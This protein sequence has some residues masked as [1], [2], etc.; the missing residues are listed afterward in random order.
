MQP[1]LR[2]RALSVTQL[3]LEVKRRLEPGFQDRIV[4]GEVSNLKIHS[5]GNRY[6]SLKDSKSQV[7][8]I[9]GAKQAKGLDFSLEEG[10]RVVV[11][12]SLQL[13]PDRGSLQL[14]VRTAK[15]DGLGQFH[16][17]FEQLKEKLRL[18]GLFEESRKRALPYFP[19]RVLLVTSSE[20]AV[21][22]DL[23]TTF[24]RRNPCVRL[25]LCP[26]PV[27]GEEAAA[28]I[29]EAIQNVRHHLQHYQCLVVARG[30]GSLTDLWTF[31]REPLVRYLATLPI[32]FVS[33]VG[34]ETDF[35]LVD[36]V[37]DRRAATPTAA[38][39]LLSPSR[40]D[41]L[42]D[43][44]QQ[45]KRMTHALERK[46]E[47][48]HSL[49]NTCKLVLSKFPQT[50]L[51]QERSLCRRLSQQLNSNLLNRIKRTA[52]EL[53]GLQ[54]AL[55]RKSPMALLQT[56]RRSLAQLVSRL[57]RAMV[58][59]QNLARQELIALKAGLGAMSPL[60]ILDRGYAIC[61]DESGRPL[62]LAQEL[63]PGQRFSLQFRDGKI[64]ALVEESQHGIRR[65]QEASPA[66]PETIT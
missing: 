52:Q 61:F 10:I 13:Y 22:H 46:V 18:E 34:H 17:M 60:K 38:A 36:F 20:G 12:G 7:S 35:T 5:S 29:V 66:S 64:S 27:Q 58:A 32:P 37:A 4:A 41:L 1:N 56:E 39:E 54:T 31:N 59:R 16:Q 47:K 28:R 25:S 14:M 62:Q 48:Q 40:S 51:E 63:K 44:Q 19:R 42:A 9:L 2:P 24:Q 50:R 53:K 65:D 55:H 11:E 23:I 6:F 21:L 45:R 49:L 30:G 43:L 33:A 8:C 15:P 26:V 57:D 3:L